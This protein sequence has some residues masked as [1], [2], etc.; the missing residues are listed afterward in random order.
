MAVTR[1]FL[2]ELGIEGDNLEKLMAEIG[3]DKGIS[4]EKTEL[5][6]KIDDLT[7]KNETL[8]SQIKERDSKIDELGKAEGLS[9]KYKDQLSDLQAQIKAKDDEFASKLS[10]VQKSNAI[11]LA[12]RDSGAK[13]SKII[14]GMLD[15]DIIKIDDKGELTGL[16][17]Q[18]EGIQKSHDYL[19]NIEDHSQEKEKPNVTIF[20]NGNPNGNGSGDGNG[21]SIEQSIVSKIASRLTK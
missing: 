19:F 11:E 14:A 6:S 13:D 16:K 20:P 2:K 12:L 10:G 5:Q 4:A 7:S 1:E 21:E 15:R 8:A 18:L 17:E 3:K 9:Q